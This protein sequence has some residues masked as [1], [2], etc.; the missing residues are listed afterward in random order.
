[1]LRIFRINSSYQ[2]YIKTR[3]CWQKE[4][5]ILDSNHLVLV[6]VIE[7][8]NFIY[9]YI[10]VAIFFCTYKKQMVITQI[11]GKALNL[12]IF[13]QGVFCF[14]KHFCR[15]FTCLPI[16]N[17]EIDQ[18]IFHMVWKQAFHALTHASSN[19]FSPLV[20]NGSKPNFRVSL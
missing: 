11:K 15:S 9:H 3:L 4:N 13:S 1:E 17:G 16:N 14:A 12:V 5:S 6:F 7:F 2:M 20:I 10:C 8:D 18:F 19:E